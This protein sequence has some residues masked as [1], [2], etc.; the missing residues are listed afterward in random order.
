MD[1][2]NPLAFWRIFGILLTSLIVFIDFML[3]MM[4]FYGFLNGSSWSL[5]VLKDLP[6]LFWH[7]SS[8]RWDS[9]RM[10]WDPMG[11][12]MDPVDALVIWGIFGAFFF[13]IFDHFYRFYVGFDGIL[14]RISGIFGTRSILWKFLRRFLR[15]SMDR[16]LQRRFGILNGLWWIV[17]GI[18][19]DPQWTL[20][21]SRKIIDW[22]I[23]PAGFFF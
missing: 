11:F 22:F 21:D 2:A 18:W 5:G 9:F 19:L 12:L 10:F 4:G 14:S 13:Y 1:P 8:I 23:D 6:G 16:S 7:L 17:R 20:Y 15:L 3:D